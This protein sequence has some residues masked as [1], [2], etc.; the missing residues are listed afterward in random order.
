MTTQIAYT[1]LGQTTEG[2]PGWRLIVQG[3]PRPLLE[4]YAELCAFC[5]LNLKAIDTSMNSL[6][7]VLKTVK[8]EGTTVF[9]N[10]TPSTTEITA[11]SDG[12]YLLQPWAATP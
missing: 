7:Q 4:S 10:I 8:A 9:A 12:E 1:S 3:A 2:T 5:N 6:Y 11:L